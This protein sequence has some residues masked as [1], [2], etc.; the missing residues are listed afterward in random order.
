MWLTTRLVL[1][2]LLS[3]INYTLKLWAKI[4]PAS[5]KKNKIQTTRN[6]LAT[7]EHF[8]VVFVR[9]NPIS[10][11]YPLSDKLLLSTSVFL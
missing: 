7:V 10:T 1:L 3:M 9:S 8:Q 6:N 11:I 4:N 2:G 5:L